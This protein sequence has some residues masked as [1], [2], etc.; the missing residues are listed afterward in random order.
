MSIIW[1]FIPMQCPWYYHIMLSQC[2]M[3]YDVCRHNTPIHTFCCR[4]FLCAAKYNYC[5]LPF[6]VV[7]ICQ[8]HHLSSR[9]VTWFMLRPTRFSLSSTFYQAAFHS[10]FLFYSAFVPL[11]LFWF[12]YFCHAVGRLAFIHQLH[13]T[14]QSAKSVGI[15]KMYPKQIAL[16]FGT[17]NIKQAMHGQ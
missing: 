12:W 17:K 15:L 7:S 11:R 8:N 6:T 5:W 10:S 2:K 14:F 16:G 1:L 4:I 9:S 13:K 3:L